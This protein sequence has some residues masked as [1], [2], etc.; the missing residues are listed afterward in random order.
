MWKQTKCPPVDE[1]RNCDICIYTHRG[2]FSALRMGIFAIYDNIDETWRHD[3]WNKL[4]RE[5]QVL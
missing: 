5:E 2:I 1:W 3:K 4:V